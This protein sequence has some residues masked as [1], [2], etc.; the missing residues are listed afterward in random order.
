M[1]RQITGTFEY[2]TEKLFDLLHLSKEDFL[3]SYT[4]IHEVDYEQ[5]LNMFKVNDHKTEEENE[6]VIDNLACL[7]RG[8]E[9]MYIEEL[10]GRDTGLNVTGS[11]F[12]EVLFDYVAKTLNSKQKELFE[13]LCYDMAC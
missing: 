1:T 6:E 9:N 7:L 5:T 8:A 4:Y 13:E 12:K 3:Q 10:N 2:D 11:Q